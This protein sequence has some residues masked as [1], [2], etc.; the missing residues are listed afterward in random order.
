M[1]FDLQVVPFS[2][3]G[4][5]IAFSRL[6]QAGDRQAGLYLRSVHGDATR[7]EVFRL[8]L[9]RGQTPVRFDEV[10]TPACLRLEA[11]GGYVEICIAEPKVV[12]MRGAGLRDRAYTW[13]SSVFLILAHE[14][15]TD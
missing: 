14:Y 6:S 13:T 8:E 4:S 15:L 10:A 2:R 3:Y 7:R 9:L 12:R 1:N 5:Y 11:E